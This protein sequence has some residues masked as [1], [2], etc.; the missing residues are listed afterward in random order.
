MVAE[1]K[2]LE[3]SMLRGQVEAGRLRRR[4]WEKQGHF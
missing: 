1:D 4:K 2:T 3:M